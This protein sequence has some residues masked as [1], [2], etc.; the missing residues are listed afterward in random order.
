MI[1][2]LLVYCVSSHLYVQMNVIDATILP[3]SDKHTGLGSPE[4]LG[5]PK[6]RCVQSCRFDSCG[7]A[8]S[9][10]VHIF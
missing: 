4:L 6:I 5:I 3:F 1:Q 9:C 2:L 7:E 10:D 8:Y